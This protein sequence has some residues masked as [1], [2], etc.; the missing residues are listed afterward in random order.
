MRGICWFPNLPVRKSAGGICW[1]KYPNLPVSKAV[2]GESASRNIQICQSGN[3][4]GRICWQK[5]PNLPVR[6][7]AWGNLWAEIPQICQSRNL[8]G[9]ICCQKYPNL[10]VTKSAWGN[11]LAEIP[12]S[13][14]QEICL[15]ESVGRNTQICQSGNLPGESAN[16]NTQIYES[17]KL[18]ADSPNMSTEIPISASQEICLGGIC[19]QKYSNLPVSKSVSRFTKSASQEICEG[20]SVGRNTQICQ[21]GNLPGGICGQKY[22]NLPVKKSAWGNLLAEIPKSA[23]QEICWGES[24]SKNTQI[25]Q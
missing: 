14:S 17:V 10:P 25:C 20:E 5:Y 11:L 9:R 22:L 3:L 24:A 6:K 15:G 19:W 4:P 13:A 16:R 23:S 7:S 12:K 1:Q 2:W 8:H 21:S 18:P